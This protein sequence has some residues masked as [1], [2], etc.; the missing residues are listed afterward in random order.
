M[1]SELLQV[2]KVEARGEQPELPNCVISLLISFFIVIIVYEIC[3]I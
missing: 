2:M 1:G 3:R